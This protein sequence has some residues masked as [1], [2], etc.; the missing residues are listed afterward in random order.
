MNLPNLHPPCGVLWCL[1]STRP[2]LPKKHSDS[3]TPLVPFRRFKVMCSTRFKP[4]PLST[5]RTQTWSHKW[6]YT[7]LWSWFIWNHIPE[8]VHHWQSNSNDTN[9]WCKHSDASKDPSFTNSDSTPCGDELSEDNSRGVKIASF[10]DSDL[11]E[12]SAG[13]FGPPIFTCF[14]QLNTSAADYFVGVSVKLMDF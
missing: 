10:T 11:R 14:T 13:K 9:S 12:L 2:P 6:R 4:F 8:L 7:H 1:G 5:C 3:I